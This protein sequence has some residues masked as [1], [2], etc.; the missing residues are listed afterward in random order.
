MRRRRRW[1]AVPL[2]A[3]VVLL[4]GDTVAGA[5]AKSNDRIL[6][7]DRQE[8]I[9]VFKQDAAGGKKNYLYTITEFT[10]RWGHKCTVITGDSERT[11]ALSCAGAAG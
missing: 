11:I 8:Y 4:A 2:V 10:D 7:G 1:L 6:R 5:D 9:E 3:L